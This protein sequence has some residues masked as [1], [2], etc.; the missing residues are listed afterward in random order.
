M[1]MSDLREATDLRWQLNTIRILIDKIGVQDPVRLWVDTR[2]GENTFIYASQK[3]M[4]EL[5][6]AQAASL[7]AQL[8]DLGVEVDD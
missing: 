1:K 2:T 6:K 3:N 5:L 7:R 4:A 8:T